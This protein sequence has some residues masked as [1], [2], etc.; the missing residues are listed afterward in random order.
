MNTV[1][2]TELP[3]EFE[4]DGFGRYALSL[5]KP[6]AATV[7]GAVLLAAGASLAAPKRYTATASL[8][9]ELPAGSDSRAVA[10]LSPVY[11][12]SLKTY[13]RFASSDSIFFDA[14]SRLGIREQQPGKSI[15]SLKRSVLRISKPASTRV[16]E[17]SATLENAEKAKELAN[18][19]AERTVDLNRSLERRSAHDVASDAESIYDAAAERLQRANVA[20]AEFTRTHRIES[21]AGAVD[22][23]IELRFDVGRDLEE[24]RSSLKEFEARA[25]A[26][27]DAAEDIAGSKARIAALEQQDEA[28]AKRIENESGAVEQLKTRREE[29]EAE[30][31]GAR[32]EAE[33]TKTRLN[34]ARAS[35]AYQGERVSILDPGIVP[36]RPSFPNTPLNVALAFTISLLGSV[37]WV[38]WRYGGRRTSLLPRR[39]MRATERS[40]T[41]AD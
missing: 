36:E 4:S 24:A 5:W 33:A 12:E 10:A 31:K 35:L 17:I 15:E 16:L 39:S 30:Q 3:V 34:E 41:L 27:G 28:L 9:V 25:A 7:A 38:A 14:I 1:G 19:I 11:L 29:L 37:M 20:R 40:Y 26:G 6:V 32:A 18:Y 13:E 21:A 8:M 22:N 2:A 23:L